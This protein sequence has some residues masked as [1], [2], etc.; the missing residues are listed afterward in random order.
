[1]V[2]R[3]VSLPSLFS[4]RVPNSHGGHSGRSRG[5]AGSFVLELI[6][7]GV[8]VVSIGLAILKATA[9]SEISRHSLQVYYLSAALLE[10]LVGVSLLFKPLA[11]GAW[12]LASILYS[13]LL[14]FALVG[15]KISDC[16]CLGLLR[17]LGAHGRTSLAA[18]LL[19]LAAAGLALAVHLR[20]GASDNE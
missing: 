11:R 6:A 13:S 1:M 12:C 7:G 4:S 5:A 2:L 3:G 10:L 19:A 16:L 18:A 20:A 17:P 8:G 15:P 14:M 9:Y